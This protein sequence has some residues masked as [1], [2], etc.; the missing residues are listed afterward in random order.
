MVVIILFLFGLAI[1]SF[2]N[3]L[4]DRSP[5]EESFLWG[6]SH[7]DW[8]H[9]T[10]RWFE[11]IPLVSY[12]VQKGRCLRC[13]KKL[14]WQYPIIELCTGTLFLLL[15]QYGIGALLVASAF[16]VIVVADSKYQLIPDSAVIALLI[17]G[18]IQLWVT[19]G[20]WWMYA[21][22]ALGCSTIFLFLWWVTRGRGMGYGD[23][24]LSGALGLLLGYPLS[25]VALYIAFLTGALV[26]VILILRRKARMKTKI[27]F[28]PFLIFGATV[29]MG[30]GGD[31]L[32]WWQQF[33]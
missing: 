4:I 5:H 13:H 25:I 22:A 7:C 23:V 28:G 26:G 30:W 1:G 17:A 15:Y 12:L 18:L 20:Q 2:L 8:C 21:T 3:V 14:S 29:A 16:L 32:Q 24:K 9:K 27:A 6:R 33:L 19:P 10:L 31:L 11:L